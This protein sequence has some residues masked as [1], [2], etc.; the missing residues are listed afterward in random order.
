MRYSYCGH[1]SLLIF[2][3]YLMECV[4]NVTINTYTPCDPVPTVHETD[5]SCLRVSIDLLIQAGTAGWCSC[6]ESGPF[7]CSPIFYLR[8]LLELLE[9]RSCHPAVRYV[10]PYPTANHYETSVSQKISTMK[11]CCRKCCSVLSSV[12]ITIDT[13]RSRH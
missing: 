5:H 6:V 8:P 9:S 7:L 2:I 13:D 11:S 3:S 1:V 12:P 4:L 10:H